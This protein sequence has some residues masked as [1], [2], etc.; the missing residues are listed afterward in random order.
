MFTQWEK[1][2]KAPFKKGEEVIIQET[3]TNFYIREGVLRISS[4]GITGQM[5]GVIHST[6]C[7]MPIAFKFYFFNFIST[8]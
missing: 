4:M 8:P 2:E 5:A 3:S 7:R 6:D 1:E